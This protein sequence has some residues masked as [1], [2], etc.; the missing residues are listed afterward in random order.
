MSPRQFIE[1]K[2]GMLFGTYR[3]R[4]TNSRGEPA[5]RFGLVVRPPNSEW[6]RVEIV[7]FGR[8]VYITWGHEA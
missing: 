5:P 7:L 1:K 2:T 8:A 4:S 6:V 3:W